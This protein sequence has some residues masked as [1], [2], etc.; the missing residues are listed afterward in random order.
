METIRLAAV[1]LILAAGCCKCDNTRVEV[2]EQRIEKLE[3][4][5]DLME[6][7]SHYRNGTSGMKT[8]P[9]ANSR[10]TEL[11]I[12]ARP[13]LS[14]A[15]REAREKAREARRHAPRNNFEIPH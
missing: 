12:R 5:L 4:R 2:L 10:S 1:G 3:R 8:M 9:S 6:K 11:P 15:E 13:A 14:P 7:M